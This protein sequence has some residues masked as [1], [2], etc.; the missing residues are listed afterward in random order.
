MK[1]PM[2]V[3]KMVK[4]KKSELKLLAV[5]ILGGLIL[6]CDKINNICIYNFL[7]KLQC[8]YL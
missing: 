8:F 2:F 1:M 3:C 6:I 7:T 5:L 4:K